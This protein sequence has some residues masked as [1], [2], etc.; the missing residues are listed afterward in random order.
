[1]TGDSRLHLAGRALACAVLGAV[2]AIELAGP[3][4][5]VAVTRAALERGVWVRPF[6][7]LVYTMPPY[8]STPDDLATIGAAMT[9]AVAEVHG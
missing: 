1:M 7:S 4:D 3:V 9:A 8:V 5:V 6:R 2:G